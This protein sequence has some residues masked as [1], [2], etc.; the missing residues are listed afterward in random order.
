MEEHRVLGIC[1]LPVN[2]AKSFR[3]EFILIASG[4]W[5]LFAANSK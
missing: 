5:W 1:D 4:G 2:R 3:L